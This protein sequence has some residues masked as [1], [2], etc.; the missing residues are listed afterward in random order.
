MKRPQL[1]FP[2][3]RARLVLGQPRLF[4][5][6]HSIH[7]KLDTA[8]FLYIVIYSWC[9]LPC[10]AGRQARSTR[11]VSA[12]THTTDKHAHT[13]TAPPRHQSTLSVCLSVCL[14]VVRPAPLPAPLLGRSVGMKTAAL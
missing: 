13:H 5:T 4:T 9:V 3:G 11:Q 12:R 10:R 6:Y 14:F 7:Y 2:Q 1:F 8:R